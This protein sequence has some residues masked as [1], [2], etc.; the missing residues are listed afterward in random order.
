MS[1]LKV[2]IVDY[3]LGNI[4]NIQRAVEFLGYEVFFSCKHNDIINS[5][6]LILPGVGAFEDG[7]IALK[8]KGMIETIQEYVN[9]N[10]PLLGIC[11]GM[12]LLMSSSEEFGHHSGLNL[13]EGKVVHLPKAEHK[14]KFYKVPHV[15]WNQIMPSSDNRNKNSTGTFFRDF[16]QKSFYYFSHSFIVKPTFNQ[17]C[18][19]FSNY[20]GIDFCSV[21]NKG[22]IWGCQFHPELGGDPGLKIFTNFFQAKN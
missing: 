2:T 11:L 19:A 4:F 8:E 7:M 3:G 21:V 17:N 15:G 14:D 20:G 13:I 1:N 5:D 9:Q 16:N 12:Q 10:K 22:N 6:R 18:L